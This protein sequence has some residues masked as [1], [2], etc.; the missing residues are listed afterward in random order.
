MYSLTQIRRN[1]PI[2]KPCW[3]KW[4]IWGDFTASRRS[5]CSPQVSWPCP[6]LLESAVT[7][8]SAGVPSDPPCWHSPSGY[9]V[10][11]AHAVCSAT[12]VQSRMA[13]Q[14]LMLGLPRSFLARP[15]A[16]G[17]RCQV[18]STLSGNAAQHPHWKIAVR[19]LCW[20]VCAFW[21][22]KP[23]WSIFL[24]YFFILKIYCLNC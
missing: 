8:G 2:A 14:W 17:V 10:L 21:Q 15:V 9:P 19:K 20:I 23:W 1:G 6:H 22:N 16:E 11:G 13:I 24:L 4:E 12:P 18:S 5:A 7:S 3:V